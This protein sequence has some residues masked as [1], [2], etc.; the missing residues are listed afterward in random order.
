MFSASDSQKTDSS[1][2]YKIMLFTHCL[3]LLPLCSVLYQSFC[4]VGNAT[5]KK[6]TGQPTASRLSNSVSL[7]C[8]RWPGLKVGGVAFLFQ[9]IRTSI[10]IMTS[11]FSVVSWLPVPLAKQLI[12]PRATTVNNALTV[13]NHIT[14]YNCYFSRAVVWIPCPRL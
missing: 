10:A 11:I 12:G 13:R 6:N 5:I 1:N 4:G 9:G 3:V 7:V 2:R 8:R 14:L